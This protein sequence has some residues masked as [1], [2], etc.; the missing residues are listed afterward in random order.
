MQ[1]TA[2]AGDR[3]LVV[4]SPAVPT[5]AKQRSLN[6][7]ARSVA[8]RVSKKAA[9]PAESTTATKTWTFSLTVGSG[10]S[11][12][13]IKGTISVDDRAKPTP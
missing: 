1:V 9:S 7:D 2:N 10:P 11:P 12:I 8:E 13:Q 5:L 4:G 6:W 3:K